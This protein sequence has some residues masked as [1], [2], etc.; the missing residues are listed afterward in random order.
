MTVTKY[1][2][3]I[4]RRSIEKYELFLEMDPSQGTLLTTCA[5]INASLSWFVV[6][7]VVILED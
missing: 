5:K 3:K 4:S 1:L 6:A 2:E 7:V